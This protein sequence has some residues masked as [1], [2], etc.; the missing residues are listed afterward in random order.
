[1]SCL[2]AAVLTLLEKENKFRHIAGQ[3]FKKLLPQFRLERDKIYQKLMSW[4]SL[5]SF[6]EV[7]R[8]IKVC[9]VVRC[10]QPLIHVFHL[11]NQKKNP[12]FVLPSDFVSPVF[13]RKALHSNKG[14]KSPS[15]V[16]KL[17][18]IALHPE[19]IWFIL[20]WPQML[21]KYCINVGEW[22]TLYTGPYLNDLWLTLRL[23]KV[24][25]VFK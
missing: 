13:K 17:K 10:M 15:P 2:V 9:K 19:E 12:H 11:L 21:T 4:R 14:S 16:K 5:K 1:M 23:G 3:L 22:I 7:T 6:K 20:S 24:V 25:L 18:V 8:Q